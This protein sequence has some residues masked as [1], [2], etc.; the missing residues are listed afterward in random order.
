MRK[1]ETR[2]RSPQQRNRRPHVSSV[3]EALPCYPAQT[4]EASQDMN[5]A[6]RGIYL[7]LGLSF[8]IGF[9]IVF[10]NI[11]LGFVLGVVLG[12]ALNAGFSA[13]DSDEEKPGEQPPA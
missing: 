9:G 10:D 13:P 5:I 2:K 3:T 1:R 6:S 8:G 7:A 12:V 4:Y 11:A